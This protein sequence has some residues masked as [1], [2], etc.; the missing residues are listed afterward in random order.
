MDISY[1]KHP[2]GCDAGLKMPTY[3]HFLAGDFDHQVSQTDLV[4]GVTSGFIRSVRGRL[5]VSVCSGYDLCH[6]LC[7]HDPDG[8]IHHTRVHHLTS[9][10]D[11][12]TS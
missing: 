11:K 2:M 1:S 7:H 5:Q 8:H 12:I 6:H 9:L 10:F 3:A 4:F